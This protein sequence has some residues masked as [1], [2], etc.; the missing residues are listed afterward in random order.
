[1]KKILILLLIVVTLLSGCA[2]MNLPGIDE[3]TWKMHVMQGNDGKV[4]A[5]SPGDM[6]GWDAQYEIDMECTA[7]KNKI[8]IKD[9]TNSN[10][11]TGTWSVQRGYVREIYYNVNINGIEG[12]AVTA[13]TTYFNGEEIPTLIINLGEYAIIFYGE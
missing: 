13:M 5:C 8:T 12:I 2:F 4:I 10:T 6:L 7:N 9:N 3:F 1:M 11:Y